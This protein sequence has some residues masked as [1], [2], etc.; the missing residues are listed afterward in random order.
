MNRVA[1]DS[2]Q[3]REA[4]RG[5]RLRIQQVVRDGADDRCYT[6]RV[7]DGQVTVAAGRDP[8]AD[9][10]LT[11]DTGTAGALARGEMGPQE[12]FMTGRIRVAGDIPALMACYEA[13]AG[14]G[15]VFAAVRRVTTW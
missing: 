9:V 15:E 7:D 10:T 6:V 5:V 11:E 13:L 2:D 12:A 3:L 14:L 4:T 1:A 8:A